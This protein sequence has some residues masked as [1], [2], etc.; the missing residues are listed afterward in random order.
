MPHPGKKLWRPVTEDAEKGKKYF[1]L[2]MQ[3]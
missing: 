3:D 2:S 1:I